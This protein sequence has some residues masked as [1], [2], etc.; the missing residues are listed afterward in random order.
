M[1]LGTLDRTPPPIFRQGISALTK[2]AVL[3]ALSL[4]LMVADLRFAFMVPLRTALSTALLPVQQMLSVPVNLVTGGAGYMYGLQQALDSA[5]RANAA[6]A[7]QSERSARADTLAVENARLRAL[8]DLRPALQT[9]SLAAEVMF[10]LRDPYSRKIL[11]DRGSTHGV[12]LGAPVIHEGGVLGQVTRLYPLSSEVTLLTD[13]EAAIPVLNPRT[14]QRGAAFG[15]VFGPEGDGLE[16][17]FVSANVDIE[18]GDVLQTSGID[19][20]YPPGLPV[21]RVLA[22]ERRVE[23]GFARVALAPTARADGAQHVLV[24]EP[25]EVQRAPRPEAPAPKVTR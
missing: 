11:I 9:R 19:G 8:L 17:R 1:P 7:R 4:F 25:L 5:S 16:L 3:S 21:A 22:V 24:L 2:L 12:L 13:K 20:I 18:V 10:E 15:G 6:L 23:S 14:Q